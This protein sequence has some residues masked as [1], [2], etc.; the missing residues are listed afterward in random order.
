[1][2]KANLK[3]IYEFIKEKN[4]NSRE[5]MWIPTIWNEFGYKNIAEK[6]GEEIRVRTYDFY[7]KLM[8]NIFEN[9]MK[10]HNE[11]ID[12]TGSVIYSGMPRYTTAWDINKNGEISSGTFL[13]MLIL[14][15]LL[16]KMGV[17]ILYLLPITE[18]S[19]LYMKGDIGAPFAMK[20]YFSLDKN[21]HDPILDEM[22]ISLDEQFRALVEAC[23]RFGIKMVLDFIPRVAARNSEIIKEHPDWVYWIK[24]EYE[25][26]FMPPE[27][28]GL[29]FFTECGYENIKK[30]YEA[31][32]TKEHLKK[33]SY[34]PDIVN[35]QLW[36]K[37]KKKA[38][39]TGEELL[40]L[41]EKEMGITT[42]P[43]HSDW[44][45]DIQP[46]WTD[47]T[48]LKLYMD[49]SP[50]VRE[51]LDK[52]QPPYVMFD[53]I[54]SNKFPGEEANT[55]L[56]NY[57]E[58]A[59][60]YNIEEFGVDGFRFDI[61]HT[62]PSGLLKNLFKTVKELKP[63]AIL[64]SED[65]FNRNNE[66]AHSA[67]YNIMLGS[68]WLEMSRISKENLTNFINE[69]PDLKLHIYAGAETHDTPRMVTR[70]GG[71]DMARMTGVMNHFLPNGVPF[72]ST[73]YEVNEKQP[74]NCGLADN[75]G[76]ADISRAFFNKM[77]IDWVNKSG[78]DMIELLEKNNEVKQKHLEHIK[79]A[80]FLIEES[81]EDT[82]V[83]S[84]KK[85]NQS[86]MGCF[87]LSTKNEVEIDLKIID[88]K[89][90]SYKKIM[91]S[92]MKSK[93]A[94]SEEITSLRLMPCH[95]VMMMGTI[96]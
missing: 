85:D 6:S 68:G 16:K 19:T 96:S 51:F 70:S 48:F 45:N 17:N 39:L 92:R 5:E 54:K 52:D 72:I 12:F 24:K 15:P 94:E 88:G 11:K 77:T 44:I 55:G 37:I 71:L 21:L 34:S 84:Y 90:K 33:F 69:L 22:D 27:I 1:M 14:L 76:G 63:E 79:E 4:R 74:I 20:D 25:K 50:A 61:G 43:A 3:N 57:F 29:D 47:I 28:P 89:I 93:N 8:E 49:A 23:H 78:R 31:Q 65:L 26:D 36:E 53:T 58:K 18:Y 13:R 87:N 30:V 9:Q 2:K 64:I 35:P 62:L 86:I 38:E 41:V 40:L 67:G 7:E 60:R 73:G 66:K 75:T 83:Y 81:P 80:K 42:P 10:D 46:V 82:I 95:G 91:D 56:W 32:S 59:L